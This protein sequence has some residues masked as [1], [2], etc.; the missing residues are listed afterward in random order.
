VRAASSSALAF[1]LL[2]AAAAPALAETPADAAFRRGREAFKAGKLPEACAAFEESQR[3][4]PEIGT[5]FN[6]AQCDEKI[7]KVATA[8]QLYADVVAHDTNGSRKASAADLAAKLAHRVPHLHIE[9]DAPPPDLAV[10]L[11]GAPR[12]HELDLPVDLGAHALVLTAAGFA[13]V[14]VHV[15]VPSEGVTVPVVVTLAPVAAL[16]PPVVAA[17]PQQPPVAAP[18]PIAAVEPE[19]A[20]PNKLAVGAVIA[21]GALLAGGAVAG[22][23]AHGKWSDAKAVCGSLAC[24]TQMQLDQA[25]SLGDQARSRAAISTGLV[26]AGAALAATGVVLWVRAP[27]EHDTRVSAVAAPGLAALSVSG[28]F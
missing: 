11:D 5:Q 28:R 2:V 7:G 21:G 12:G 6:L 27:R 19:R 22:V 10:I 8:A 1:L 20:G 25:N 23:L 16:P 24:G 4:D 14:T 9:L 13:A 3:L 17:Q 26:L 18:P 15:D